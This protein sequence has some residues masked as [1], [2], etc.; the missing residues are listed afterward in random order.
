MLAS[1]VAVRAADK[2]Y[3]RPS[4]RLPRPRNTFL[5]A[6]VRPSTRRRKLLIG[7]GIYH[8]RAIH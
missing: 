8:S 2:V 1:Q 6:I 7:M 4:G 5:D 3:L